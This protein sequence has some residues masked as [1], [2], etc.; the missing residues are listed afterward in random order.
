MC[1]VE[2]LRSTKQSGYTVLE[3]ILAIF[4][5]GCVTSALFN[6]IGHTD[7]LYGRSIYI[8]KVTALALA[9]AE[10]LRSSAVSRTVVE[11]STYTETVSGRTF[12]IEREVVE[13]D[14]TSFL[15]RQREPLCI[16]LKISEEAALQR[17]PIRF[18]LLLGEDN[19]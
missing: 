9:E 5:F 11:D 10:R 1:R 16:V 19:P 12:R 6:L 13:Q 4:I 8:S 18:R 15:P 3:V 2:K 7:R 17:E 14:E